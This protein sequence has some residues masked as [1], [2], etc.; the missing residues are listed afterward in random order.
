MKVVAITRHF[1]FIFVL[2][3]L[4][5]T[6]ALT[7]PITPWPMDGWFHSQY[8]LMGSFPGEDNYTPIAAPAVFY[9]IH[10]LVADLLGLD[11][12]GEFY[13]ASLA[14]NCL[15]FLSA[16]LLLFSSQNMGM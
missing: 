1:Q 15:V 16:C 13:L 12:V 2:F 7:L 6:S 11:F 8:R 10:H 9:K 14:Q 3:L 5:I 4:T